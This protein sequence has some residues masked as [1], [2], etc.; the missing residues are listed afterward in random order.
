MSAPLSPFG[1]NPP[2]AGNPYQAP[3]GFGPQYA[4]PPKSDQTP[5]IAGI[6]S[7]VGGLLS[8]VFSCC[9]GFLAVPF[10]LIAIGLGIFAILKGDG[11]AK[12][13]GIGGIVCGVL[14]LAFLIVIT[15]LV[16]TNPE[17]LREFQLN[18]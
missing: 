9:C 14:A 15:I 13:L 3:G 17:T 6:L 16:F 4:P 2:G 10:P 1:Q 18:R 11:R 5:M 12:A 8:I 7:L